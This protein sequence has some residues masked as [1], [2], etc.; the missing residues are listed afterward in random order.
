MRRPAHG[1]TTK[2]GPCR[3]ASGFGR[4]PDRPGPGR[5]A[6]TNDEILERP[7]GAADDVP[8]REPER[9]PLRDPMPFDPAVS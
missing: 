6:K 7:P 5:A 2:P 4:S 3:P 9:A 8:W 1:G